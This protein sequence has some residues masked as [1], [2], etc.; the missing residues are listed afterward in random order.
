[1]ADGVAQL[2]SENDSATGS[3]PPTSS[4]SELHSLDSS[5]VAKVRISYFLDDFYGFEVLVYVINMCF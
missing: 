2:S 5:D 1:V 4:A 3:F